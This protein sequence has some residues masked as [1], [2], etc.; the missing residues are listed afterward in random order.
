[1]KTHK[2]ISNLL[3]RLLAVELAIPIC[4]V[5]FSEPLTTFMTVSSWALINFLLWWRLCKQESK[6]VQ[7]AYLIVSVALVSCLWSVFLILVKPSLYLK[8][9]QTQF[10][11]NRSVLE[12]TGLAV[13]TIFLYTLLYRIL[14][15]ALLFAFVRIEKRIHSRH[16]NDSAPGND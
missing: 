6:I 10:I 5:G 8:V 2:R 9:T 3:L 11:L 13:L 15:V 12:T 1:M 7:G 4:V 14:L 16:I